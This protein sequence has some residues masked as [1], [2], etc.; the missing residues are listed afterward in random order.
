MTNW[1]PLYLRAAD[2]AAMM[3]A[4]SDAGLVQ[5][6]DGQ[7]EV[8]GDNC[9]HVAVLGTL[10]RGTGV[11]LDDGE[12]GEYEEQE[13]IPGY[14]VNVLTLDQSV[15]DAL[16]PVTIAPEPE[17]PMVVWQVPAAEG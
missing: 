15:I 1:I 2:E 14:H 3:D 9:T 4:L 7:A 5:D 17:T 10:S 13:P 11:M 16:A 8:V 6:V 12:G